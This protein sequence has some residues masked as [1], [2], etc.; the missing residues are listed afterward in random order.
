MDAAAVT[1]L[2]AAVDHTH[3]RAL[4]ELLQE[5]VELRQ[6]LEQQRQQ[7]EQQ[8]QEIDH[9]WQLLDRQ[10]AQIHRQGLRVMQQS[11][12]I[13]KVYSD[14]KI[15]NIDAAMEFLYDFAT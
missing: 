9:Q 6:Q 8:R 10:N 14:L 2:A 15:G 13:S 11:F 4:T 7:L 3:A 5:N 1:A 12:V